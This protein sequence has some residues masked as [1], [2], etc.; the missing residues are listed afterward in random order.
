MEQLQYEENQGTSISFSSDQA[1]GFETNLQ[2]ILTYCTL[3]Q[4]Q[5]SLGAPELNSFWMEQNQLMSWNMLS[6]N[7]EHT[8]CNPAATRYTIC[9]TNF[10]L[11]R[12]KKPPEDARDSASIVLFHKCIPITYCIMWA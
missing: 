11:V 7:L 5:D 8:L 6:A 1:T 4:T 3:V 10:M 12:R 2:V 9:R